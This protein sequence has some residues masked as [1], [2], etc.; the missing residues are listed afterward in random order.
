MKSRN[1]TEQMGHDAAFILEEAVR[2]M[3]PNNKLS[4]S[5]ILKLK[6]YRGT[7]HPHAAQQP[8]ALTLKYSKQT[9]TK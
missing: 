1:Y 3:L 6:A 7:V 5:L 2:G 9:T 8:E 4:K